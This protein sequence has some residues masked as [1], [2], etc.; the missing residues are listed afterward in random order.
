LKL[1]KTGDI[2][3][4]KLPYLSLRFCFATFPAAFQLSVTAHTDLQLVVEGDFNCAQTWGTSAERKQKPV[5]NKVKNLC[6][7]FDLQD[8]WRLQHP[9]TPQ[10]NSLNV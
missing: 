10:N 6:I 3:Y 8:I 9:R 5:I 7:K 4:W 1:A 2:N